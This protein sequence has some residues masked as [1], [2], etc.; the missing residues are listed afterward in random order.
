MANTYVY[1]LTDAAGNYHFGTIQASS[2][3]EAIQRFDQDNLQYLSRTL[4]SY[5]E[6]GIELEPDVLVLIDSMVGSEKDWED[7]Q[8]QDNPND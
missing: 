5:D 2:D 7:H 3:A 1:E 8:D 4:P 6:Y